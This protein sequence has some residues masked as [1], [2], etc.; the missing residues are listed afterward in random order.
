MVQLLISFW[1]ICPTHPSWSS[2]I[3]QIVNARFLHQE[4]IRRQEL[5]NQHNPGESRKRLKTENLES[6]ENWSIASIASIGI[7]SG[8]YRIK[9]SHPAWKKLD[10]VKTAVKNI[11]KNLKKIQ[12]Q[13]KAKKDD[14]NPEPETKISKMLLL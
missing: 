9:S 7:L 8:Y 5:I 10:G 1:P 12:A 4:I 13:A 2:T 11:A 14:E 6:V 3:P